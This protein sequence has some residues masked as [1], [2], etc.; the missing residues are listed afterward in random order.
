MDKQTKTFF[1]NQ[2]FLILLVGIPGCGKT[3][4]A[5]KFAETFST[6]LINLND[7]RFE[8]F[9]EPDFSKKEENYLEKI[10]HLLLP[11]LMRSR[12]AIM[13]EGGLEAR[14]DRMAYRRIA[15]DNGYET[16]VVWVQN[17]ES[18]S[19][20]RSV[21][22]SKAIPRKYNLTN[23]Q[24]DTMVKRFTAP[25]VRENPVVISGNHTFSTQ[26]KGVLRRLARPDQ[27]IRTYRRTATMPPNN[28]KKRKYI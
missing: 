19:R 13:I 27:N 20:M 15:N 2:P 5:E 18:T 8:L 6:P 3:F 26:A 21:R 25:N 1:I 28:D 9:D 12:R 17:T 24:F 4:F 7:L 14:S 22:K 16:V 10:S 23:E 11:E